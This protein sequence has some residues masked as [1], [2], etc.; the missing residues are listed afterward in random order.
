M[1][2]NRLKKLTPY[3]PGEQPQDRRYVK[4]NTNENPYPPSPNIDGFLKSFD[5]EKL[6]LYPDPLIRD[7]RIKIAGRHGL[8]KEN[9][10]VGNGSDEVLSFIFYAFF[11]SAF[12]KLLFPQFTY[13]FY[14]VYC[15]FYGIEY[16][17]T[18]LNTDF[19][20]NTE[21]FFENN[22]SCGIIF[23]NPNAPTGNL[24]PIGTLTDLLDNYPK[25]KVVAIDEA[26]IDFGGESAVPLIETYENLLVVQTFS[27]SMSLAGVRLGMAF[28]NEKL[29]QALFSVKDSFNSYPVDILAQIIGQIALEDEPYYK[30]ITEKIISNRDHL[31]EE[32]ISMGWNVIPSKA[33]FIF[34][35]KT[36]IPG[37]EIYEKLKERGVLVRYF[38]IEGIKDFVRITIGTK[39]Q[40]GILLQELREIFQG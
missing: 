6:R 33:N 29:I 26:Y 38:D 8:K 39:E 11:D 31:S 13:S 25:D 27:K 18:P 35:G 5:P 15:D 12:G 28:G 24:L 19:S 9:V 34:A 20:I 16:S 30:T 21:A 23:S 4:L 17:T 10:F 14:P 22:D 32:M 36:G 1:F 37:K 40:L 3:I 7:L 2:S